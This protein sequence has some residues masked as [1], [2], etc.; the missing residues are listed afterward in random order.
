MSEEEEEEVVVEEWVD[1]L[2]VDASEGFLWGL[3]EVGQ[4]K[5]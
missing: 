4:L 2:E 1:I 5:S 3:L